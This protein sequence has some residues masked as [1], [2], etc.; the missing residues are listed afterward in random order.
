MLGG[1]SKIIKTIVGK[2]ESVQKRK[3]IQL[4][5]NK[6]VVKYDG[7]VHQVEGFVNETFLV[8]NKTFSVRY[9]SYMATGK[10]FGSYL[11][12]LETS[13]EKSTIN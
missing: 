3:T 9:A 13:Y 7:N 10:D 4:I 1:I 11:P 6:K 5:G 2:S 12:K 8:D